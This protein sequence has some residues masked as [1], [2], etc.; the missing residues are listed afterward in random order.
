[1]TWWNNLKFLHH[2][3]QL[4][5]QSSRTDLAY[6]CSIAVV[7]IPAFHYSDVI[8][9]VMASQITN[10]SI[11]YWAVCS[12]A[13]K[14]NVKTLWHWPLWGKFPSQRTSNVKNVSIWW[15]HYV[16]IVIHHSLVRVAFKRFQQTWQFLHMIMCPWRLGMR[17]N[18][19]GESTI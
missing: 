19:V 4:I 9:R 6:T 3:T 17:V 12:G 5:S 13:D 18:V 14:K 1:M 2:Q 11:V 10:F 7:F 8:M 15:R 16:S